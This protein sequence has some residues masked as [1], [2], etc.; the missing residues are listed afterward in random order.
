MTP[1]ISRREAIQQIGL[2]GLGAAASA[3]GAGESGGSSDG[4][5]IE[6]PSSCILTPRQVEGPYFVDTGLDRRDITEG[7]PGEP[8]TVRIQLVDVDLACEPIS[9]AIVEV[10]H[11][12]AAGVYSG[13]TI[14]QGNLADVPD[15]T[16]LRGFQT[17]DRSGRVEFQTI[18]PGWYPIRTIHIHATAL[19]GDGEQVTTQLYFDQATNDLVMSTPPYDGRGPQQTRNEDDRLSANAR[20]D[21][22]F[23]LDEDGDRFVASYLLG[24]SRTV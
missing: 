18:Y 11:S 24:V 6:I 2:V 3:C 9:D 17:T 16:F 10:W 5:G 22:M 1:P 15:E 7:L 13:F 14:D 21:L 19:L 8:L 23:D 4:G 20:D 12:D